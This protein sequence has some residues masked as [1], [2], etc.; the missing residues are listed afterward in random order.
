MSFGGMT[1]LAP[2]VLLGLLTL[3]IV[4]WILRISPP[5]PRDQIFPPLRILEG[6]AAEEETPAGTPLWLLIFRLLMVALAVFALAQPIFQSNKIDTQKRPTIF[7]DQSVFSAPVWEGMIDEAERLTR[8]AQRNNLE[9]NLILSE[10]EPTGFLPAREALETLKSL[11]PVNFVSTLDMSNPPVNTD[12][13]VLSSGLSTTETQDLP[14]GAVIFKPDVSPVILPGDVRETAQGF[15]SDWYRPSK[16]TAL[17]HNIEALGAGGGVIAAEELRFNSGADLGTVSFSLPAQLRSRVA[18]LR[19]AG[20]RS[21]ASINLLDDSFGRPLVGV[22]RAN[23]DTSSPLLTEPFYAK[24]ALLPFADVFEGDQDT[25]LALKPSILVMSDSQRSDDEAVRGFVE[26]GGVLIRFAGPR[27]AKRPDE[28]LPVALRVGDRAIGG[29]LAWESPQKLADFSVDSPFAGLAIP[30]DVTVSKQV[31]AEPGIETDTRTWARLED[32]SPIVTSIAMGQGRVVLFHVTAGPNWSNLALSGL[33]VDMLQRLL[34]LAKG[35]AI[36]QT[37]STANWMLDRELDAFGRLQSPPPGLPA[38][39]NTKFETVTASAQAR[40][41]TYRQGTRVRALPVIRDPS[42]VKDIP[43]SRGATTRAYGQTSESSLMGRLL[44]IALFALAL[45]ALFALMASGRL[46][47]LKPMR[48][49]AALIIA[50][51]IISPDVMAQDE[52]RIAEAAKGLHLAYIETGDGRR[53]EL[54]RVAMEGLSEQLAG[55]TTIE[56]V[57]VHGLS[58][59]AL[60]LEMYPFLY[61]PVRRDTPALTPEERA[62]INAYMAAGGTVVFDTGDEG[63]RVLRAG[64]PH[65]GLK[66]ISEGLD[67]PR[68]SEAPADHVLTKSFYLLKVFPGRWANGPI[69]V[70]AAEAGTGGRDGVSPVII[71][72]ND[73]AA[74]WALLAEEG[75]LVDLEFDIPRQREM[76]IRFGV[77]IAMYALSGN[78]KADQVHAAALIERLGDGNRELPGEID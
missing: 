6:V 41:G 72:S 2:L 12:I 55:R 45:D 40:P 53:D 57:G 43:I 14:S 10:S 77:N 47:Y 67:I 37:E 11:Q 22:L 34:P 27:L 68:L 17:T 26:E 18:R 65:P 54:S 69:Y 44:G 7:I 8:T 33:Y 50:A 16:Q 38:L 74:G 71:G 4:W 73:W 62:N 32:G 5:K 20:A 35:R 76:S 70:Q 46:G 28:L 30:D 39:T 63:D 9:V 66:R 51:M 31:M 15:D 1:F 58:P 78:Y 49:A 60:G 75:A 52:N 36:D 59:D 3:P 48:G 13:Y 42:R 19:V 64:E 24:Q 29:A 25:L 61:W 56:P 21:A 23:A